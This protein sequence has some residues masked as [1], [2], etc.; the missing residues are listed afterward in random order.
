MFNT[1]IRRKIAFSLLLQ[2]A[3]GQNLRQALTDR[4]VRY[5]NQDK[6]PPDRRIGIFT[7]SLLIHPKRSSL[8][9]I[10]TGMNLKEKAG[11]P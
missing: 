11:A 4:A 1:E 8:K 2:G 7:S 9:N 5:Y 6:Y 3:F 10:Q